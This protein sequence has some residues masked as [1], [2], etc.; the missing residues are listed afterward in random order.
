MGVEA[1]A[2]EVRVAPQAGS[3]LR[4]QVRSR[5]NEYHTRNREQYEKTLIDRRGWALD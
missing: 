1:T 4:T 2:P 3:V 5:I